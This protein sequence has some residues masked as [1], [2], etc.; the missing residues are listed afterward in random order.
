MILSK[1]N[2]LVSAKGQGPEWPV[3]LEE[4]YSVADNLDSAEFS[5]L[6]G[7]RGSM[8]F[9]NGPD[10]TTPEQVEASLR[11]LFSAITSMRHRVL[12]VWG[13]GNDVIFEAVVEYGRLDGSSVDIAAVSAYARDNDGALHGRIYCDLAPVF[14]S[15][16]GLDSAQH[17]VNPGGA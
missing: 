3:W 1:Q 8:R 10:L 5:A 6:V 11:E 13:D 9:G 17:D 7:A 2:R 15:G 4:L 16:P 14:G 12:R